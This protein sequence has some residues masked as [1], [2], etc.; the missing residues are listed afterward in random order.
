MCFNMN[1]FNWTHQGFV[2]YIKGLIKV[3]CIFQLIIINECKLKIPVC[4]YEEQDS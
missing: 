3:L 4:L 2:S 1:R